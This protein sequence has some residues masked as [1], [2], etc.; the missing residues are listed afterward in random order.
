MIREVSA[1]Y[2]QKKQRKDSNKSLMKD[3][4]I[5]LKNKQTKREN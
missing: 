1:K 3:I 4:K 2:C 5:L